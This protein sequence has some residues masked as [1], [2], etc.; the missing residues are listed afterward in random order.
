MCR[1]TTIADQREKPPPQAITDRALAAKQQPI[2]RGPEVQLE[3]ASP[4][5]S[6]PHLSELHPQNNVQKH[7]TQLTLNALSNIL[8][9][10]TKEINGFPQRL[11][12]IQ[13]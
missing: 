1:Q 3:E 9:A 8:P 11:L 2:S 5:D 6:F 12:F 13:M 4:A 10:A 7:F